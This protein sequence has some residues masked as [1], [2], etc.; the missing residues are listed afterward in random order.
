MIK[1]LLQKL[2]KDVKTPFYATTGSAGMDVCAY[3]PSKDYTSV[4]P[5]K[6]KVIPTG[7]KVSIPVGF[8]MQVRPRSGLSLKTKLRIANAPGTVDSDYRGEVGVI[9]ENI[10]EEKVVI[11]HGDRIA[12]LIFAPVEQAAFI[13]VESLDETERGEGGFGSTGAKA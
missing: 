8:E 12:Q 10:S 5:N 1:V 2:H 13:E 3:L 11:N 9:I 4:M 6:T 7:I